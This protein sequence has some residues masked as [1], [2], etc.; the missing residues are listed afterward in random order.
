[1]LVREINEALLA[2]EWD[3]PGVFPHLDLLKRS[4][5]RLE[6]D[7]GLELPRDEGILLIR[8]ARQFGKSTWLEQQLHDTL[9]AHGRG[10]AFYLNGD[11]IDGAGSLLAEVRA[12]T[13]LYSRDTQV[14][15]L[16]VDEVTAIPDWQKALKRL[17]DADELRGLLVVTTG[18]KAADLR[19]A[20]ER[21][22]GRKGRL[23]RTQYIF[24]PVSYSTFRRTFQP[25][26]SDMCLPAYLLTGGC[27][28]ACAEIGTSG[29]IPEFVV[30]IVR[31]WVLGECVYTGRSRASLLGVMRALHASGG[32]QLSQS[33]LARETG[34]ANN[35]VAAGYV[36][37]LSDLM[38]IG[39]TFAWD[40]SRDMPLLRR[41][42]KHPFIN[43]LAAVAWGPSRLRSP[44]EFSSLPPAEQGKW[45]EWLVAQ[46]LWRRAATRGEAFPEHSLCWSGKDREIDFVTGKDTF[47]ECKRGRIG[48]L[49]FGWFTR[50]FPKAK[51]TIVGATKFTGSS[52]RGMTLESFLLDETSDQPW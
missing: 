31:D 33:H 15:R 39:T 37:V 43:L 6:F 32:T 3:K 11:E 45:Q 20:G 4:P 46:E 17:A 14:R 29:R 52:I 48:P 10:S 28:L 42:A 44:E 25:R 47:V 23:A 19:R 41:P 51:L 18:S 13:A 2:G 16:F 24:T 9:V 1:M 26:L 12:L 49:D 21:L 22:P 30:E 50:S 36:E 34:L 40:A 5:A 7:F 35:T 38:C 27:P 8:G